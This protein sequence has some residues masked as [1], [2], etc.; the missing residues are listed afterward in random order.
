MNPRCF[1]ELKPYNEV[2]IYLELKN[3]SSNLYVIED[4][5]TSKGYAQVVVSAA[6]IED[7]SP[8]GQTLVK[9]FCTK[10]QTG[11]YCLSPK[12]ICKKLATWI[13]DVSMGILE[14][15]RTQYGRKITFYDS[16]E[17][18]VLILSV[19]PY[20][21]HLIPTLHFPSFW[22]K[23]ASWL[24]SCNCKWP[25]GNVK[26]QIL[27][28][29]THLVPIPGYELWKFIF[30]NARR[31]L[32][33]EEDVEEKGRCLRI[34]KVI[35][36]SDLCRPKGLLP[37]HLENIFMWASRKYCNAEDWSHPELPRRFLQM[38]A[39]LH[40]CLKNGDCHN[41]F[42]PSVNMLADM[43]KNRARTLSLKVEDI[44]IDPCKYLAL[45]QNINKEIVIGGQ[46]INEFE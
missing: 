17:Q 26:E 43:N 27:S 15:N 20:S 28:G 2:D 14:Q 22:P 7:L 39:A 23:C 18:G 5:K 38:L 19:S 46:S 25:G 44:M 1:Y 30:C 29:G 34:L 4:D 45:G 41:F 37:S 35:A 3:I 21:V 42:I 31:R 6:I 32:L 33:R 9:D 8:Q 10:T 13:S 36:E 24:K 40:R 12:N 11:G 16:S